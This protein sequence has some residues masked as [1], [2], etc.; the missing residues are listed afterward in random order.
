[1]PLNELFRL[2]FS[3]LFEQL[4]QFLQPVFLIPVMLLVSFLIFKNIKYKNSSYYQ[5][6]KLPYYRVKRDLGRYG[7]YL[8]YRRLKYFEKNSAKFLFNVYIPKENGETT[9]I[10]VLL[11][12][13][14]GIF[15]FESK[16]YSGWIFGSDSQKIWYQTL[17]MGKGKSHKE[18]FFNP[19]IQND[20]HIQH[21]RSF[22]GVEI[23][24]R[25]VI[26]FSERCTLKNVQV[27]RPDVLLIKRDDIS[28]T[29]STVCDQFQDDLLTE[30]EVEN[31]YQRLYPYTQVDEAAKKQHIIN[32]HNNIMKGS[33]KKTACS[34]DLEEDEN[35]VHS[36][37]EAK[38]VSHEMM[39]DVSSAEAI[40]AVPSQEHA[41][42]F[43][44]PKCNSELVL[45]TAS[46]GV[47]VG[48]RFYGCSNFP[49]CRYI[50][51]S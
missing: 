2:F 44:C 7:E 50:R 34:I 29:V 9:E 47:N 32:I 30:S 38:S 10:D 36:D 19:I 11:I 17:P 12:C 13:K 15:V 41:P 5:C 6:T 16:N 43:R 24:I 14:K 28:L 40:E 26:V 25:S 1:M 45:R 4:A 35:D 46:K 22:L 8:I 18:H 42:V 20:A 51:N 3:L 37:N 49:K 23:P 33:S 39:T 27:Q 31:L 21:L 48:K